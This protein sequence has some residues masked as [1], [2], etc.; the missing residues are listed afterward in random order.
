[1]PFREM[2]GSLSQQVTTIA[3]VYT[4]V[5]SPTTLAAPEVVDLVGAAVEGDATEG[6]P[7]SAAAAGGQQAPM[8]WNNN[9]S[10]FVLRRMA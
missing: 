6:A 4:Y 9:T 8:R 3:S 10:E 7:T 5:L 2:M 1:M